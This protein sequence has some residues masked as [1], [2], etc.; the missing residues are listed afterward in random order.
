V[1]REAIRR[2][3]NYL[4]DFNGFFIKLAIKWN[5]VMCSLCRA[6]KVTA[7]FVLKNKTAFI[8]NA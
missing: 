1:C 4:I 6:V 7:F 5:V 3:S 8:I 2:M